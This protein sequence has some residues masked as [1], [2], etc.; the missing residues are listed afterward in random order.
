MKSNNLQSNKKSAYSLAPWE[1][2]GRKDKLCITNIC[3]TTYETWKSSGT[4]TIRK[5]QCSLQKKAL[6]FF[7]ISILVK[8]EANNAIRRPTLLY[9][10]LEHADKICNQLLYVKVVYLFL[11]TNN[12]NK[13][14][15]KNNLQ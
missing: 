2:Q 7:W 5:L 14:V 10:K 4:V 3:H 12:N 1:V 15:F 8:R 13:N 11:K 9:H 6:L